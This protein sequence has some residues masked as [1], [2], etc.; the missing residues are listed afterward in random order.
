MAERRMYVKTD[1]GENNNKFWEIWMEGQ[2]VF[3]RNGR[4]GAKG[5]LNDLGAGGESLYHAKIREKERKDYRL[6]PTIAGA[7]APAN[8]STEMVKVAATEQIANGCPEVSRLVKRLAEANRHQLL[9]ASGGHLDLNLS[10]GIVSTPVGVVTLNSISQARTFLP[11]FEKFVTAHNFDDRKFIELIQEYLMLVPQK[12]AAQRG[13]HHSVLPDMAALVRQNSLLDQLETSIELA[14]KEMDNKRKAALGE[15]PKV[16]DVKL[17]VMDDKKVWARIEKYFRE[18]VNSRHTSRNLKPVKMYE[19]NIGSMSEAWNKDGAKISNQMEL[20]HGT[21]THNLLSIMKG[22]LII[23]RSGGSIHV[24]GRMFGDG[25]YFSDQSTKALNYAQGYWDGGSR[26]N[27]CF[28][29]LADVA[30]GKAYTPPHTIQKIPAGY[31]SCFAKADK[32]GV[33]NNEMIVYRTS[34]A[35]L[36]YLIEFGE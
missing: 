11:K 32:S 29:F 10:T 25:L 4:V 36:K 7:S 30:M 3:T 31:D 22:G 34:Q 8:A 13:W 24:T 15:V 23:P 5:Q 17:S 18:T 20:W 6:V 27:N 28:M 1:V 35:N 14:E 12:V 9:A 26:D 19:I 21:R 33:M 16:F 2:S